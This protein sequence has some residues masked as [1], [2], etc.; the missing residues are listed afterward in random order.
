LPLLLPSA[1]AAG[2][3]PATAKSP[4][5]LTGVDTRATQAAAAGPPCVTTDQARVRSHPS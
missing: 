2:H 3:R 1:T 4:S 5:R